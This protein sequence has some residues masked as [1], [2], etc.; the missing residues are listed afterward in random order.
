MLLDNV[1]NVIS[2]ICGGIALYFA[3]LAYVKSQ[4]ASARTKGIPEFDSSERVAIEQIDRF[5]KKISFLTRKVE[6]V[7]EHAGE[8]FFVLH[9]HGWKRVV[10]VVEKLA[11]VNVDLNRWIEERRFDNALALAQFISG[12][13][14]DPNSLIRSLTQ[15]ELTTIENWEDETNQI[16][17]KVATELGNAALDTKELG[18]SRQRKRNPTLMAVQEIMR[19]LKRKEEKKVDVQE[20]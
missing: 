10:E 9:D 16:I 19:L 2:V 14:K 15:V 17:L 1:I 8:Y 3:H 13:T 7:E 11:Q 18:I 5:Q 6:L 12:P 4:P 20:W